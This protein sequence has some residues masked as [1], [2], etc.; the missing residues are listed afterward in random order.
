MNGVICVS[1]GPAELFVQEIWQTKRLIM[2]T[3]PS[4]VFIYDLYRAVSLS[5]LYDFIR[6]RW[7]NAL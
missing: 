1:L 7:Q 5:F 3:K 6:L 4:S 2:M